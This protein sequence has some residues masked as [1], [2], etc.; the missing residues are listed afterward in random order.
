LNEVK[1]FNVSSKARMDALEVQLTNAVSFQARV[2]ETESEQ[3][4]RHC[5][6]IGVQDDEQP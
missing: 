5:G 1:A 2:R 3:E 4:D 6:N